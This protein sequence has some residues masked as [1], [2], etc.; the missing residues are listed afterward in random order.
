[1][2]LNE[3]GLSGNA[4]VFMQD[5]ATYEVSVSFAIVNISNDTRALCY[6]IMHSFVPDSSAGKTQG[7]A[8]R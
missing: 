7:R 2:K 1:M 3:R 4:T 5:Y 8:Y 6:D